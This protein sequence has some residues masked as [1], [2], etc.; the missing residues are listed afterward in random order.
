VLYDGSTAQTFADEKPPADA[1]PPDG[2]APAGR[3]QL[4]PGTLI[5]GKLLLPADPNAPGPVSAEVTKPT[6]VSGVTIVPKGATLLCATRGLTAQRVSMAC[7]TVVIQGVS[8][9]LA[10]VVLGTDKRPGLAVAMSE[11]GS[12]R[13]P[14]RTGALQAAGEVASQL[15]PGGGIGGTLARH[16]IRAGSDTADNA[17]KP[18]TSLAQ[19]EPA[20]AGTPFLLFVQEGGGF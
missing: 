1:A 18:D 19:A 17:T 7:T 14:A 4:A 11:G 8:H 10:G 16:A 3:L 20:P 2:P 15:V 13:E 12:S 5:A 9:P 6:V